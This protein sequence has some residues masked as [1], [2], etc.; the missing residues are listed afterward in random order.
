M[1]IETDARV[2]IGG[3]RVVI[4][5]QTVVISRLTRPSIFHRFLAFL[6]RVLKA[7]FHHFSQTSQA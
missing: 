1:A 7:I 2:A 5:D 4:N 3:V 6:L